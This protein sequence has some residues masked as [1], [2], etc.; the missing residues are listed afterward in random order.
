[1]YSFAGWCRFW[2]MR[3]RFFNTDEPRNEVLIRRFFP[4]RLFA[5][6][7]TERT[8]LPRDR[9]PLR[10]RAA[11][12]TAN[13]TVIRRVVLGQLSALWRRVRGRGLL[14]A[15]EVGQWAKK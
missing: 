1:M 11:L 2:E 3:I 13:S 15:V 14:L 7:R 5:G 10:G 6:G 8:Q 12:G 9:K 4:G